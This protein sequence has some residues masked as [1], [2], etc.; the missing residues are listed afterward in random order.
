MLLPHPTLEVTAVYSAVLS[1]ASAI[2]SYRVQ[3]F[4]ICPLTLNY[5]AGLC[6]T[7]TV[8]G[9]ISTTRPL[10]VKPDF[11]G[12]FVVLLICGGFFFVCF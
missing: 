1:R 9:P 10:F 12:L 6:T 3:E 11:N 2:A 4:I 5:S 8:S 7:V